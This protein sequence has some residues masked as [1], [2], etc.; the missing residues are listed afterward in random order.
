M[1]ESA[2]AT[3]EP[4]IAR[5]RAPQALASQRS[6]ALASVLSPSPLPITQTTLP[7]SSPAAP[8][9][10]VE[11]LASTATASSLVLTTTLVS[12]TSQSSSIPSSSSSTSSSTTNSAAPASSSPTSFLSTLGSSP[13]NITITVLVCVVILALIVAILFF[14]IRRCTRRRKRRRLGDILASEYGSPAPGGGGGGMSEWATP[15]PNWTEKYYGEQVGGRMVI[16]GSGGA[17]A[18]GV[19]AGNR[20]GA[21]IEE[22]YLPQ[23]GDGLDGGYG[24]AR[25]L[26]QQRRTS[27]WANYRNDE[28]FGRRG[29]WDEVDNG[30]LEDQT[31]VLAY[32]QYATP[33]PLPQAAI[34]NETQL[35]DQAP[36][37]PPQLNAIPVRPGHLLATNYPSYCSDSTYPVDEAGDVEAEKKELSQTM[38]D[39]NLG[40][41][42]NSPPA[43]TSWRDSLDWVMG[44]AADLIGSKLL[45]RGGSADTLVASPPEKIDDDRFTQRPPSIRIP[46]ASDPRLVSDQFTPLSPSYGNR[47]LNPPS[48]NSALSRQSSI[49][50]LTSSANF[51]TT[52][53]AGTFAQSARSRLFDA[54]L[55][56]NAQEEDEMEILGDIAGA[57]MSRQTTTLTLGSEYPPEIPYPQFDEGPFHDS[58]RFVTS[59]DEMSGSSSGAS[60]SSSFTDRPSPLSFTR[61]ESPSGSQAMNHSDSFSSL[62]S[63]ASFDA[64]GRGSLT[65]R[66]YHRRLSV[67]RQ[68]TMSRKSKSKGKKAPEMKEEYSVSSI[69]T[70]DDFEIDFRQGQYLSKYGRSIE[71]NEKAKELLGERRRRSQEFEES[72]V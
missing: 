61:L 36:P 3:A 59:P 20:F 49:A 40:H 23:R 22:A 55:A 57:M 44:S 52:N 19:G 29:S 45:A 27:E 62:G 66:E 11:T 26:S 35:S 51:A 4:T 1:F 70:I 14:F 34:R 16:G 68:R 56:K 33:A 69:S 13:L 2:S 15:G 50:S 47:F 24:V 46:R 65:P 71:Q 58:K 60:T 25:T 10:V 67:S 6:A 32:D 12:A 31:H 30:R 37:P 17:G 21:P 53:Q 64:F 9:T 48:H 63:K 5:T 18:A 28:E 72:L 38:Q 39:L 54:A 42:S 8:S 7:R 43:Q 41:G